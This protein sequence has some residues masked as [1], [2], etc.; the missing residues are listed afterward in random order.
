[1]RE[2]FSVRSLPY[3]PLLIA[4]GI[5]L[6]ALLVVAINPHL[7]LAPPREPAP[8]I[9][10][11]MMVAARPI[12]AGTVLTSADL[13]AKAFD[14]AL[15]AGAISSRE[16]AL[17]LMTTRNFAA[18]ESLRQE[19]LHDTASLGIAAR[20][21]EG[22]RAFSIRVSEDEIVGGFLQSGDHVDIFATIPGSVFPAMGAQNV[23]DR[24]Q[25]VLLLQNVLVLAVGEN[26]ATRGSVQAG[27][28]T[29]TLSLPPPQ[30]ARL[31][32]ALR[33]GKASLAVRKPGDN[34]MAEPANATLTDLIPAAPARPVRTAERPR[35]NAIPFYAGARDSALAGGPP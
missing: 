15:P 9:P 31:T 20:V 33:F 14:G 35:D 1:M 22:E 27:A 30:L 10:S 34:G 32:L 3:A 21:P 18:G 23:P 13:R 26:P 16:A 19:A 12:A 7:G 8:R 4:A 28:R 5:L 17:G 24:S 2:T 11:V 6:L 25:S 29:V